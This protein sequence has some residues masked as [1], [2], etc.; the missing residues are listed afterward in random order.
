MKMLLKRTMFLRRMKSGA[1]KVFKETL[2]LRLSL[3]C[4]GIRG[5]VFANYFFAGFINQF[6]YF[7]KTRFG[8][9]PGIGNGSVLARVQFI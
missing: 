2:P 9:V 1:W 8:T 3:P 7:M 5:F 4:R 6:I